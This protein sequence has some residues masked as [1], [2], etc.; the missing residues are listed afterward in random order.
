MARARYCIRSGL[1]CYD[2]RLNT[3]IQI[4]VEL[5]HEPTEKEAILLLSPLAEETVAR[6]WCEGC[7]YELYGIEIVIVGT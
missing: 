5:D 3:S 6:N 1:L 2:V 4:E 7:I